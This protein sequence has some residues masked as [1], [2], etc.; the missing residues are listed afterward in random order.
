MISL[1]TWPDSLPE[2]ETGPQ[3]ILHGRITKRTITHRCY[4]ASHSPVS[5]DPSGFSGVSLASA[6]WAAVRMDGRVA[7][8]AGT[9]LTSRTVPPG[10]PSRTSS[11][12][13]HGSIGVPPLSLLYGWPLCVTVVGGG[14]SLGTGYG[15]AKT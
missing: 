1:A 5:C 8:V 15:G 9:K 10:P 12:K 11:A 3:H 14:E 7:V 2:E 13:R 6:P 4:G